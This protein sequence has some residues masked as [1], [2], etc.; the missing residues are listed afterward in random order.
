MPARTGLNPKLNSQRAH[1]LQTRYKYRISI[2]AL[3]LL[4]LGITCEFSLRVTH[5]SAVPFGN[6]KH[7][8]KFGQFSDA[9]FQRTGKYP[10]HGDQTCHLRL[11]GRAF[12]EGK[13]KRKRRKP[14]PWDW[15]FRKSL[16]ARS[17]RSL[18]ELA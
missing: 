14:S 15:R 5:S 1:G 4:L 13:T 12:C 17:V 18:D 16:M 7:S 10:S 2:P 9:Y 6:N 11:Y 8:S 3:L